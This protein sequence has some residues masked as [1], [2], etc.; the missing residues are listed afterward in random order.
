MFRTA[1]PAFAKETSLGWAT[2]GEGIN[3]TSGEEGGLGWRGDR[4]IDY[5]LRVRP[6]AIPIIGTLSKDIDVWNKRRPQN[7]FIYKHTKNLKL[8]LSDG[9]RCC[10][11]CL[12]SI[13]YSCCLIHRSL[14]TLCF[15]YRCADTIKPTAKITQNMPELRIKHLIS[16][17]RMHSKEIR[18]R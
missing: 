18:P 10:R 8:T 4:S 11:Q 6:T 7:S 15:P 12:L 1:G 13:I 3:Q 2:A 17:I 5:W 14:R 16:G 9:E